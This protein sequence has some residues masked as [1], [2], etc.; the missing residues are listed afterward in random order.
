MQID[1]K[2]LLI[3][4]CYNEA[5]RIPFEQFED[6]LSNP[7]NANIQFLFVDDGSQD[8]TKSAIKSFAEKHEKVESLILPK[9]VGK[10][11]AIRQALV[12]NTHRDFDFIGFTDADLAIPL[13]EINNFIELSA[14]FQKHVIISAARVKLLGYSNIKN[15]IFRHVVS[16][17][18]ATLISFLLKLPIYD[19]QCGAKLYHKSIFPIFEKPF[20]SKWLFDVEVLFRIKQ[21][22]PNSENKIFEVPL[23]QCINP[24]GSK[25]K[26]SYYI[27][28]P[29]DLLKIYFHYR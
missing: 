4:P 16:R 13:N 23:R 5:E 27:K 22:I 18:F 2:I 1:L 24:P 26:A 21:F 25:I 8:D 12:E 29:I 28:A 6:F 14:Q 10:G 15:S 7:K 20:I 17:S 19:S 3:I 9:N 11:N